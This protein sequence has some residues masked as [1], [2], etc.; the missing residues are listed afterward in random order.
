[1]LAIKGGLI[2]DWS[3]GVF[4]PDSTLKRALSIVQDYGHHK[5]FYKPEVADA[6]VRSR[7]GDDFKVYMRIV[8]TKLLLSDVLDTEHDIR[9]TAVDAHRVYSIAYSRRIAEVS[10][11]GKPGEHELAV[12]QD[13][14]FLWRIYGYWFFEEGDG[15]VYVTCQSITLTRDLPF[16][17]G[18]ILGPVLREL[19]GESVR[20]SLE[21]T[22]KAIMAIRPT[23]P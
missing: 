11:A 14:G 21:Q 4:I 15:G 23:T 12:G 13:R 9:F 8:K 20:L 17:F 22:K 18:K 10:D 6:K 7:T 1:M 3:G 5:D 16:A 19:P 2:Q